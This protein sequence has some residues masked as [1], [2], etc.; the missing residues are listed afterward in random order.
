METLKSLQNKKT[1]ILYWRNFKI[2]CY[3]RGE[4]KM[5]LLDDAY[6]LFIK[7]KDIK[8]TKKSKDDFLKAKGGK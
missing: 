7:A 6:Q 1:S 2:D 8:E 4:Y 5:K 3:K